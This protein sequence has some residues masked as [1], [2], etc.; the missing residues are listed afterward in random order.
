[1]RV[2]RQ[3]DAEAEDGLDGDRDE[4]EH[5]GVADRHPPV[6]IGQEVA[7]VGEPDE[8]CRR[9]VGEVGVGEGEP[10]RAGERPAG[11][12]HQH[13]QHRRHEQPGRPGPLPGQPRARALPAGAATCLP[14]ANS[15]VAMRRGY[16]RPPRD[17]RSSFLARA[18]R[19]SGAS[20]LPAQHLVHGVEEL[21]ADLVVLGAGH[22]RGA[23]H[24]VDEHVVERAEER[25]R[26][27]DLLVL[28]EAL[29]GRVVGALDRAALLL[30]VPR[31]GSGRGRPRRPGSGCSAE[32]ASCQPPSAPLGLPPAPPAGSGATPILSLIGLSVGLAERPGIGPVAHEHGVA[33]LEH[34]ARLLLAVVQHAF[35]RDR[36]RSVVAAQVR[37]A[38]ALS[39]S[40]VILPSASTMV[41]P[42]KLSIHSSA[43]QVRPS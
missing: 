20:D 14:T 1:M 40:T 19:L 4:R 43:L 9:Q 34:A 31:S 27:Q 30:L 26:G 39:L 11:H 21:G 36:C 41:P 5:H 35:R 12:R 15:P 37:A 33:R 22:A 29:D 17:S 18:A 10:D 28:V 16:Q 6:G 24:G 2:Q 23:R 38:A 42:P 3:R 8:L 7:E 25:H 13:D 32:T